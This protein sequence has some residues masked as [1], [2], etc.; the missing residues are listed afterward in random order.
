MELAD[1]LLGIFLN[2]WF[3]ISL[4]F[5]LIILALV[6]IFRNKKDAI[7]VFFPLIVMIKTK[8]LNNFLKKISRK[9]PKFWRFFFTI[10][11]FISFS[12]MIF[13]VFFFFIN[14]IA[15]IIN[16]LPINAITPLIPGVTI[17]LPLYAYLI[18]PILFVMTT[19]ELAHGIAASI[20]NIDVKSTGILGGGLFYLIGIGAF[21]EVE[22]RELNSTKHTKNTRLRI[23]AAG[24]YVNAITIGVAFIILLLF[25]IL[26]A[27]FYGN[28][29]VQVDSVLTEKEGGYNYGALS[30]GD[31]IVA[32]K[33][34]GD[35]DDNYIY[36]DGNEGITLTAILNN[37]ING[38]KCSVDDYLT[39]KIYDPALDSWSEKEIVLGPRY[40]ENN[41]LV[42]VFIGILSHSYYLPLNPISKFFT[43][44]WPVFV[45]REFIWLWIISFSITLFNMLPL[46]IFDGFRMVK[47]LVNWAIGEDYSSKKKKKDK[48]FFKKDEKNY[49]LSEYRVEKVD[50]IKI[51]MKNQSRTEETTE[52]ILGE[53]NYEL[54][55]K[56]GDGFKSTVLFDLPK[57]TKL[58][59]DS[60][61]EVFY[62]YWDD[63]K[64]RLKKNIMYI[65]GL[66]T[67][68]IVAGNFLL[69][70]I[71]FGN[72]TFWF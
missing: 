29:V 52:I 68:F 53:E 59:D 27:P 28:Q 30:S 46:P 33:Q 14:L 15:L 55:D 36:L 65:I 12:F 45:L 71:K 47:E 4:A 34:K 58:K 60:I 23:A 32:L 31:V 56:I 26:I 66:F 35:N 1:I 64:K 39:L 21:V 25:P 57:Q 3:L 8:K 48:L 17:D 40:D 50:S 38:I 72:V 5:W 11:I 6:Y 18:V 51:I 20:D 49:G 16:P 13:A 63:N 61:I 37:K 69:S 22:E 70:F 67:L 9:A 7:Y 62:E 2:P 24:T 41:K 10:G 42:G 43:G 19:H 44:N 54:I